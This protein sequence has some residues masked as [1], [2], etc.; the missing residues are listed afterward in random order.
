[1]ATCPNKSLESWKLLATSRGEDVAYYL[2]DKYDGNVPE[3]ESKE[4]IV[5]SG[6]RAT[7]ILQSNRADSVFNSIAKNRITGEAFWKKL[8]VDLGIPKDQ[9]ALMKSLNTENKEELIAGLLGN[10]SY[11]VEINTATEGLYAESPFMEGD[12]YL[13]NAPTQVY[14]NLTVPGGT[15]YTENEIATP[16]IAPSIQG[17]AQFSTENG[18]GWF[19]SDDETV[20]STLEDYVVEHEG[21]GGVSSYT[22]K[23]EGSSGGT[24]TKTRR[25]LEMQSDLFQKGRGKETLILSQA[26][27]KEKAEGLDFA[28]VF[29]LPS[30]K[31][32]ELRGAKKSIGNEDFDNQNQFLQLLNKDNNWI[33]FFIKSILQDSA[34]KGYTK[35]LF[36][37]GD[38]AS[39]V[40]GH[41]TL[42]E[43]KKQKQDRIKELEN[44][45][46]PKWQS[47]KDNIQPEAY[48]NMNMFNSLSEEG[49]KELIQK[50]KVKINQE[51]NSFYAEIEQLE[52]ELER[53]EGPEGFGA[54]KPIYNFY[55]NTVANILNKQYGKE[56]VKQV[57]DEFGN[58]WNEIT[59]TPEREQ[60]PVM[61]QAKGT[62]SSKA[63]PKVLAFTKDLLK[64]I[65]VDI[66][67]VNKIVVN[68]QTLDDNAVAQLM[69]KLVQVVDGKQDVALTEEAMHFV[70]AIIKQ[71]NPALY[72]K[73]MSEINNYAIKN[74]V[75]DAYSSNPHYQIDGK[76]DV[77]KLKEEAIAKLL[78]E[79]IIFQVE[80]TTEKPELM[81]K[82]NTWWESII[83]WIK[84]LFIKSGFDRTAMDLL[85]GK[86]EGT[87]EDIQD[88]GEFFQQAAPN[89][90]KETVDKINDT[91]NKLAKKTVIE[92]GVEVEKYF[93]NGSDKAVKTRISD[94]INQYYIDLFGDNQLT[95]SEFEK[96]VFSVY[97][98][99]G[100][101]GHADQ[102]H[103]LSLFTD[104]NGFA[105]KDASGNLIEKEDNTYKPR[106]GNDA[107]YKLLKDNMR[108]RIQLLEARNPGSV[109]LAERQIYDRKYDKAG[110]VD[111]M[112][113]TPEGKVNIYD[114]KFMNM[115][116]ET[117]K[118]VPWYKVGAWNKQM[119][120]YKMILQNNYGVSNNDFLETQMVPIIAE[121]S[122]PNK[123]KNL[124]P[125]L[126]KIRIGDLDLDNIYLPYKNEEQKALLPV[127][128]PNEYMR[129]KELRDVVKKLLA[130]HEKMSATKAITPEDKIAK[131]EQLNTLYDA[132]RQL[133]MRENVEPLIEQFGVLNKR[134]SALTDFYNDT[135]RDVDPMSLTEKQI[136]SFAAELNKYSVT[137]QYT[138]SGLSIDLESIFDKKE[139][140]EKDQ[141]LQKQLAEAS[142]NAQKLSNKIEKLSISFVEDIIA[143][144]EGI[145]E[146]VTAEKVIRGIPR[147]FSSTSTVQTNAMQWLF[148][149]ANS[150]LYF[151][152]IDTLS[153]TKVLMDIKKE[154]DAWATSKGLSNKDYFKLIKHKDGNKLIDQYDPEFYKTL[155]SKIKEQDFEWIKDN[156]DVAAF[157]KEIDEELKREL[158]HI[159]TKPRFRSM[160]HPITLA[161]IANERDKAIQKY[162]VTSPEGYGWL[163]VK[164]AQKF[165]ATK[166]E[167]TAWK[168]LNK[169]ENAPAKKFYDYII[170][171]NQ[172]FQSIGYI[173]YSSVRNFLPFVKKGFTEK[174][175]LGGKISI[176][177]QF[178]RNITVEPGDVGYGERDAESGQLVNRIPKYFAKDTGQE[179]SDD[180]FR[181]MALMNDMAIRYD[182][183]DQI[184][185]QAL[186][187]NRVEKNKEAIETSYFGTTRVDEDGNPRKIN[188][189]SLN[190]NLYESHMNAIIYGHKYIA[191]A[192]FDSILGT[193]GNFGA[194]INDKIG[195]K[196]FPENL[197][198]RQLS[199][200]K[201][202]DTVTTL[203]TMKSLG[204]NPLS[205]ISTLL[206]GSFQSIINAGT[207]Q[208]KADFVE[209]EAMLASMM[210]G[211]DSK[212]YIGALEYFLPLT[213]D[214]N[215]ELAKKLSLSKFS[216][217]NMQE[218]LMSWMRN[219][220][221]IVQLANFFSFLKNT[222]VIDDKVVNAR[223]YV[224]NSEKYANL[225]DYPQA[226]RER[227]EKEYEAEVKA[228]IEEKGVLK[229]ASVEGDKFTIPGVDQKS[230][231][232]V[233]VRR[234]VQSL[235]KDA[236]GNLSAD[237]VRQINFTMQGKSFM[238]FKGWIPRLID[239]RIGGLK[240]NSGKTAYEWGR[241][242]MMGEMLVKDLSASI[243]S[244]KGLFT[245]SKEA[246]I[247]QAKD[248]Y[249][250]K[251]AEYKKETGKELKMTE[252]EF[253]DMM[254]QNVRNQMVDV[255]FYLSLTG[256]YMLLHSFEPEEGEEDKATRNRYK[257]LM[258][259]VD[260]VRDEVAYFYDPTQFVSLTTGGIF[261]AMSYLDN[262]KK[263][264]SNT[265]AE[266]YYLGRD[267]QKEADKNYV[268]KYYLKGL[269]VASQADT[270]LLM[271]FPDIAKDLGMRAQ[272]QAR[273]MGK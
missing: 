13:G 104:D 77:I 53:V 131:A 161:E 55:E 223:V 199:L 149:K 63:S 123:A 166:W 69:Q 231:S 271:F 139:L 162:D 197:Q 19:R 64:R 128:L 12:S 25:I 22:Q 80:G 256:L 96:A 26:E 221:K 212:K 76:P 266:M 78:T 125:I 176:G 270:I 21:W 173:N 198:G 91:H 226:E 206:G 165:P 240:Y 97:A 237:D 184:E 101:D 164:I 18:I 135:F 172:Y 189:N 194:K 264:V 210:Y 163:Q 138:Y 27:A 147:M 57:T 67:T 260:K 241:S 16:A 190:A 247:K 74:Q 79:K 4:S 66:K 246:W 24:S 177:E 224:R 239:V 72:K 136:N 71:T 105:L 85:A 113:I 268:I 175:V 62:E 209:A 153:E 17:H 193:L 150:S 44:N 43:F 82:V 258:R 42:E 158:D 132:V 236:L 129:N 205:S 59:I 112:V 87:A 261:P 211:K 171:R 181:T 2:W 51:I 254:N 40:E 182:Y 31:E 119:S 148:T 28:S 84:S 263:A 5:K 225:Y 157:K 257:Y 130:L 54:L 267:N 185:Q 169:P 114:W 156:I 126:L 34:K 146:F 8:Q 108:K 229:L 143:K 259:M 100:T 94:I 250:K 201:M 111:L 41:T 102:E 47:I 99:K 227:L 167:S 234:I 174:L 127:G 217:E 235:T 106:I 36:P 262:L 252:R 33:T 145:D 168:E 200:N 52:Q 188:D 195:M 6:L 48:F 134:I 133:R 81:N 58:T 160:D 14:A 192:N 35:V 120:Q 253:I 249:E 117:E 154:Y 242:R 219:A 140:T 3:S 230:Q 207:Y 220:D 186:L 245:G 124:K 191:D 60:Q 151:G 115:A 93:F 103:L 273:P 204:F 92:N 37:S 238:L 243:D 179:M 7:Y 218:L 244:L 109:Y 155:K 122:K 232:V 118:D 50:E 214:Y 98:E 137:L 202:V 68:G 107:M 20:G 39:K 121:Y 38:T 216:Q 222:V 187:I 73:L 110:T 269:P 152:G 83:D 233:E 159:A 90:Q 70:V 89:K 29:G 180:L 61:L 183:F 255:M 228:L 11:A 141:E 10:Y 208:T 32:N 65:G 116:L 265:I 203:F 170:K 56:N 248:T 86:M 45:T 196:L 49:K 95:E 23:Y 142:S 1:M 251:R 30:E 75:F 213:E 15:N 272:S 9:I 144:R 215:K 46:I 88:G 178:L